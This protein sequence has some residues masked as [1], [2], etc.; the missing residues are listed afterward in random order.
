MGKTKG[1]GSSMFALSRRHMAARCLSNQPLELTRSVE[2][3]RKGPTVNIARRSAIGTSL[4]LCIAIGLFLNQAANADDTSEFSTT[5]SGYG[6]IGGSYT[7]DSHL[8]YLHN[9]SE[10][11][12]TNSQFDLGLDSRIGV[13]ATISYGT[14]LSVILQ[15]EAKRRGSDDF[16]PGTEWAFV[17][18]SP[19][20]D[21]KLRLGRVALATFL[22][23]D[24]RDVGYAQPWFVA[25]NEIYADEPFENLDGGQA[26]WHGHLGSFGLDL[27]GAYGTTSQTEQ[28]NGVS[29]VIKA[30]SAYNLAAN[31]TYESFLLRVA[32]TAVSWPQAVPLSATTAIN[33]VNHD[34]F[35]SLGFQYD[36]STAIVLAEWAKR[37]ENDV[38]LVSLPLVACTDWY[39]AG[40]WRF[41]KWTPLVSYAKTK[42]SQDLLL[43]TVPYSTP[44]ASL[45]YDVASNVALKAQLMRPQ[46]GNDLYWVT[47]SL[48]SNQRVNVVGLGADFVF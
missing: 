24:F 34:K 13:Q 15:E 44:S 18:Y 8:S 6:T 3:T 43:L 26:L 11:K 36:N 38:P 40:G 17:Q 30:K 41:G 28:S 27:E 35:L 47:R 37:T 21:V 1:R 16:S 20:T 25:P 12:A 22:M 31:L 45:R 4:Y 42:A 39:V 9:A 46:A 32:E 10:F 5:I 2:L 14:Q 23:S 48:T 19:T 7:G 29:F 33:Y